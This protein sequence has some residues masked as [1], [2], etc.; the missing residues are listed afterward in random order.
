MI[1]S[2]DMLPP[3]CCST[4]T[5]PRRC[6][7][8]VG[9]ELAMLRFWRM[10]LPNDSFRSLPPLKTLQEQVDRRSDPGLTFIE[11]DGHAVQAALDTPLNG[12]CR[13][14]QMLR[15]L[16]ET[17]PID[18]DHLHGALI[19]WGEPVKHRFDQRPCFRALDQ[20]D[21]LRSLIDQVVIEF[22]PVML[23]PVAMYIHCIS[24]IHAN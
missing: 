6:A 22:H 2:A 7:A 12:H 3:F 21:S 15:C 19:L 8:S 14:S 4:T 18:H 20:L 13:N 17:Q 24:R 10:Q 1:V 5:D 16:S 9:S 23:V 11:F